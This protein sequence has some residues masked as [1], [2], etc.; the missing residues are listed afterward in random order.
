[1][2]VIQ[3]GVVSSKATPTNAHAAKNLPSTKSH[4]DIGKVI[5]SSIVPLRRSSAQS[6]IDTAGIKKTYSHG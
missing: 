6:R 4:V 5:S 2:T 3:I 1:M